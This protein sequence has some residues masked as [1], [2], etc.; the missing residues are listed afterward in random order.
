MRRLATFTVALLA[1]AAC[2]T[3]PQAGDV[4]EKD[5]DGSWVQM[6]PGC[7]NSKGIATCQIPIYHDEEWKIR[8]CA[9]DICG[10]VEVSESTYDQLAVGDFYDRGDG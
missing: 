5:Y 10:W 1:L 3:A 7:Y 6:Q 2:N 9:D 8:L 4:V